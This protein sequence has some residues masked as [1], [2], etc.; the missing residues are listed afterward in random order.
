LSLSFSLTNVDEIIPL[1]HLVL[2]TGRPLETCHFKGDRDENT[3][4]FSSKLE[5]Q[6]VGCVSFMKNKHSQFEYESPYQLRGMA[7][8]PKHR[9]LKIGTQLLDYAEFYL[10]SKQEGLIWC[11]VRESAIQ[12]YQKQ[13]YKTKGNL[14]AIKDIGPHV[15]MYKM[16]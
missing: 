4:H 13:G 1:R 8:S 16:L 5:G 7:V 14:F 3:L 10:K 11:N 12:F 6:V 9:R 15:V 2:R